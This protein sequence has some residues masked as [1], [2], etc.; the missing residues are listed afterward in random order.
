M[1]EAS[2]AR[3]FICYRTEDTGATAS[4]LAHDLG[5]VLGA[6]A[7]FLDHQGM[8]DGDDWPQ[9][10][11]QE[12][13]AARVVV[14]LIGTRWLTATHAQTGRPRLDDPG[15]WV[16]RE[17]EAALASGRDPLPLRVDEARAPSADELA[18]WPSLARLADLHAGKLR[19]DEWAADLARL[20]A[21]LEARGFVR[22]E[23][24]AGPTR[25]WPWVAAAAGLGA[26]VLAIAWLGWHPSVPPVVEVPPPVQNAAAGPSRPASL[27]TAARG[28][29]PMPAPPTAS[30]RVQQHLAGTVNVP[31]HGAEAYAERHG[32]FVLELRDAHD[33]RVS[34]HAP[35]PADGRFT[36]SASRPEADAANPLELA[37]TWREP[38]RHALWPVLQP[39]AGAEASLAFEQ[40]DNLLVLQKS[41]MLRDVQAGRFT[42]ADERLRAFEQLLDM[43]GAPDQPVLPGFTRDAL[44]HKL[45]QEV[46]SA[47][48]G[49][50][51]TVGRSRVSDEMLDAERRWRK[52]QFAAAHGT[53]RPAVD[54]ARALNAWAR[55]SR[56]AY[57]AQQRAWTDRAPLAEP[58]VLLAKPAYATW[59]REDLA[60]VSS[61]LLWLRDAPEAA[62]LRR[63]LA[64]AQ[65]ALL[66]LWAEG[67]DDQRP[68]SR[69][70]HLLST[71]AGG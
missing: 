35:L 37:W 10:L 15:D 51:D 31:T 4:R 45:L 64:P 63:R 18:P 49:H 39:V 47:A 17:V 60:A 71:L 7:V 9:R 14:V 36:L 23:R 6:D 66:Q 21:T 29:A 8:R 53:E 52:R 25:R 24:V 28:G 1:P 13:A 38:G 55:F 32:D 33:G 59:L 62:A 54:L 69:L 61:Q 65:Q 30:P 70:A 11:Q 26:T 5:Q 22:P 3:L 42:A 34:S 43:Y 41:A 50:R 40:V 12:V 19:R 44:H 46:C 20:L 57:S 2:A 48:A 56:E 16:R 67:A 68:L 58:Q 27:S